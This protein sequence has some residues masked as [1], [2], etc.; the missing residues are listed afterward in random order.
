MDAILKEA[1]FEKNML[2]EKMKSVIISSVSKNGVPNASYAP[3]LM[4]E[5]NNFYIYISNLSK[6]ASNLSNNPQASIMIIEDECKSEFLFARKRLTFDVDTVRI[7]R[8]TRCWNDTMLLMENK[9]GDSIKFLK[10]LTDFNLFKLTP[11]QALLVYGFGKAFKFSDADLKN[12]SFMN[13]RGHS[14]KK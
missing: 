1:D 4:D 6:H 11:S 12:A 5:N 3:S 13:D 8:D 9:F 7:E 10:D 14:K 2:L